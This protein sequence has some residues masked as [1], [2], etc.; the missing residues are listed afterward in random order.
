MS[1]ITQFGLLIL[2]SALV[3]CNGIPNEMHWKSKL[4]R[5]EATFPEELG[6]IEKSETNAILCWVCKQTVH[7][8]KSLVLHEIKKEI[9]AVCHHMH[10]FENLCKQHANK[11]QFLIVHL[12]FR[13]NSRN[14]CKHLNMCE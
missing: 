13:G 7:E 4:D 11:Y 14:T 2:F 1:P 12:L 5:K 8:M 6:S 10:H 3:G 9:Q